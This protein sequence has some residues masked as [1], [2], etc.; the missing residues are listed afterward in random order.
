LVFIFGLGQRSN[1]KMKTQ[2]KV[3]ALSVLVATSTYAASPLAADIETVP[4]A[5]LE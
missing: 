2:L 3:V 4:A 5:S 1:K